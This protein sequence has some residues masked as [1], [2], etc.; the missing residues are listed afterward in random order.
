MTDV[1]PT[2]L[3]R[4]VNAGIGTE[5]AEWHLA[6]GSVLIDGERVTDPSTPVG[7]PARVVLMPT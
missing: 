1:P 2:V 3:D 5:R 4:M 7:M 6:A